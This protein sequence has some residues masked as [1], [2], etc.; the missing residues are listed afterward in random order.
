MNAGF[1][2]FI[3]IIIL[4]IIISLKYGSISVGF[5]GGATSLFVG[6]G[7]NSDGDEALLEYY[8]TMYKRGIMKNPELEGKTI[9]Q[10]HYTD[11]CPSC[12]DFM[13]VWDK[14]IEHYKLEENKDKAINVVFMK[15]NQDVCN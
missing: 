5:T 6:G 8:K 1:V 13:P 15:L 12:K 14:I 11:W 9:V 10:L 3:L 7:D 4:V 2:L